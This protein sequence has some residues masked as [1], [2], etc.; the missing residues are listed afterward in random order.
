M[1][2]R[3]L[4]SVAS[5]VKA[6]FSLITQGDAWIPNF[7]CKYGADNQPEEIKLIDFQLAR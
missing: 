3:E 4:C 7:L 2:Y 5:K 1:F 6:R